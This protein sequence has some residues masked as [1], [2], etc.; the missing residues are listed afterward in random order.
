MAVSERGTEN[1]EV[2]AR[3]VSMT[4]L[5]PSVSSS[6]QY[7]FRIHHINYKYFF[8]FCALNALI[9]FPVRCFWRHSLW[10]SLVRFFF[11]GLCVLLVL[12]LVVMWPITAAHYYCI[13]LSSLIYS[14][15]Y[16]G[17]ILSHKQSLS[18]CVATF[19]QHAPYEPGK[20]LWDEWEC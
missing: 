8:F 9:F 15:K 19:V 10:W 1:Q 4:I 11:L 17:N 12:L 2:K 18:N 3:L 5:A 20:C 6:T 16:S 13:D 7:I 14:S